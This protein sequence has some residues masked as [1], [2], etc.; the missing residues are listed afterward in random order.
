MNVSV[1]LDVVRCLLAPPV[2]ARAFVLFIASALAAILPASAQT[3]V[4]PIVTP[5]AADIQRQTTERDAIGEA[6][7]LAAA[8]NPL[9]AEQALTRLNR[10]PAGSARW[11]TETTQRLL[12]VAEQL[13]REGKPAGVSALVASALG[14]LDSTEALSKSAVTKEAQVKEAKARANAKYTAGFIHERFTGNLPAALASYQ[15]A[16]ELDP[17]AVVAKEAFTRLQRTLANRGP[18]AVTPVPVV[19]GRN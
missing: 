4:T 2:F 3:K 10:A 7:A 15:A 13:A 8:R 16:V 9:A 6:K 18:V 11:H 14:H 12:A 5:S 17:S 19:P 1:V